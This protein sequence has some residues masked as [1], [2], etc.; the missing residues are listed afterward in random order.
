MKSANALSDRCSRA[1][2]STGRSRATLSGRCSRTPYPA[3][4]RERLN[5]RDPSVRRAEILRQVYFFRR[6]PQ[7]TDVY[8]DEEEVS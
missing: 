5:T 1:T 6:L 7:S 3:G 8:I 4:Y 2:Y